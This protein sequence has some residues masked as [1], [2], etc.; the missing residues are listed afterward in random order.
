MTESLLV[1]GRVRRSGN[2]IVFVLPPVLRKV[3]QL[4]EGDMLCIRVHAP[5]ATFC[6]WPRPHVPH[7]AEIP[8]GDR[9]PLEPRGLKSAATADGETHR[10]D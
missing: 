1:V 8:K 6:K 10:T 4:A 7:L 9:P 3:M 5:Y 2:S